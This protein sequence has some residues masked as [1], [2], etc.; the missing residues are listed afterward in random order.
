MFEANRVILRSVLAALTCA[1]AL[2]TQASV[3]SSHREDLQEG[4]V[5]AFLKTNSELQKSFTSRFKGEFRQMP[6]DLRT[7]LKKALPEF[8]FYIAKMEVYLDPPAKEYDLILIADANTA[9]VASFVWG[10]YWTLPPS[11]SFER[12]L[13]GHQ[14]RSKD[15]ALNHVR[16]LARLI[17]YTSNDQ[18][19]KA[20]ARNG[21][22]KIELVRGDGVFRVLTVQVDKRLRFGRLSITA[23][24]GKTP[25]YFV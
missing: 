1:I 15:D 19:G 13:K 25:R 14:A 3:M 16:A 4:E 17:T 5:I 23:S 18:V 12:I 9:Q 22:I 8:R 10:H 21:K 6:D 20:T 2:S 24:N 7:E 11:T